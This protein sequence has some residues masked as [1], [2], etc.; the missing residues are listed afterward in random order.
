MTPPGELQ[1]KILTRSSLPGWR[2]RLRDQK[3]MLVVTNGCFDILHAGHVMYLAAARRLGDCLLVGL[4]SDVSVCAIKG[5]R[6]PINSEQDRAIVLAALA[7]VD[8]VCVFPETD[9]LDFL[10]AAEPDVYVKG[11]DYT[12]DTMN[13]RERLLVERIGGRIEIVTGLPGRSSSALLERLGSHLNIRHFGHFPKKRVK[14]SN[15]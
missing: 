12:L 6:R 13:Q 9:A 1:N 14:M 15:V 3:R 5:P 10:G 2:K 7:A 11:G 8:V 4:N